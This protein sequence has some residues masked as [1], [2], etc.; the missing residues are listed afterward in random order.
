MPSSDRPL[1]RARYGLESITGATAPVPIVVGDRVRWN[2]QYRGIVE[3]VH[4]ETAI[5]TEPFSRLFG[6]TIT[7]RLRVDSLIRC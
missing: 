1:D 7:W 2:G 5:V 3:R 6:R 4:G